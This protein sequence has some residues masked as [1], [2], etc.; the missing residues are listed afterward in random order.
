MQVH[1]NLGA[2]DGTGQLR[3]V[4]G[5]L[6]MIVLIVSVLAMIISAV[7]WAVTNAGG[8]YQTAN[9][10]RTGVLVAL[11]AAV[12]AGSAVAWLKFLIKLGSTL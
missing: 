6:L 4:A 8:N 5:A 9:R 12:L 7:V 11:G 2:L 1:P 10:G 3:T